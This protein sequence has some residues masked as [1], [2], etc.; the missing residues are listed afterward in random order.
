LIGIWAVGRQLVAAVEALVVD[1][2]TPPRVIRPPD[3]RLDEGSLL[4]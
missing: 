2:G 3:V 1:D 4:R